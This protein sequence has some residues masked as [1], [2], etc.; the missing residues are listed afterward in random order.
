MK[1]LLGASIFLLTLLSPLTAFA[2]TTLDSSSLS[3]TSWP[4][5][6]PTSI[7]W[8]HTTSASAT[9]LGV[10]IYQADGPS[11]IVSSV[12]YNGTVM[13][14]VLAYNAAN[15]ASDYHYIY[16]LNNPVSGTKTIQINL[17][18]G[19]GFEIGYAETLIGAQCPNATATYSSSGNVTTATETVNVTTAGS[20]LMGIF[21]G[22][23]APTAAI[24]IV[25][26]NASAGTNTAF[27]DSN[28]VVGTGNQSLSLTDSNNI[29]SGVIGAFPPVSAVAKT[30]NF[31]QFL[32]F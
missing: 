18:P 30:F 25:R 6:T 9:V 14:R 23:T 26:Q 2:A 1:N 17:S 20:W 19:F 24:G 10:E 11:D 16:C 8:N 13:T 27:M 28:G 4:G 31:W 29:Y 3:G 21:R 12:T 15:D 22:T 5:G 7:S 32:D